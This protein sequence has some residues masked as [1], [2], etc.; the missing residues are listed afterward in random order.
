MPENMTR[1]L[2]TTLSQLGRN[3]G[4]T[5]QLDPALLRIL[6][7]PERYPAYL[8]PIFK[9]FVRLPNASFY[10]DGQLKQ[11][12]VYEQRFARPYES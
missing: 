2:F 5:G 6:A 8:T 12:G 1:E 4:E 7:K 9:L 10:W 3:F 11:N